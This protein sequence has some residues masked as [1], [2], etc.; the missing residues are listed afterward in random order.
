MSSL[1]HVKNAAQTW[2]IETKM[3]LGFTKIYPRVS[4][5]VHP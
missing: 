2:D 3:D 4:L 5:G 1:L